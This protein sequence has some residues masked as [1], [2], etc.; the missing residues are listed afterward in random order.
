[1]LVARPQP[2]GE[3]P[4]ETK[5]D[6]GRPIGPVVAC[7][8]GGV[9]IDKSFVFMVLACTVAPLLGAAV[10]LATFLF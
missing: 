1:M 9:V 10:Y 4:K 5:L 7:M 6:T 3:Q 8:R 2:G